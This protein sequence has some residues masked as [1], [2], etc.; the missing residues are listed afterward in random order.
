MRPVLIAGMMYVDKYGFDIFGLLGSAVGVDACDTHEF[1]EIEQDG[2]GEALEVEGAVTVTIGGR[3][4]IAVCTG[5]EA[6]YARLLEGRELVFQL[7]GLI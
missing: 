5:L 4:R 1:E 2:F 7:K 3:G 6:L